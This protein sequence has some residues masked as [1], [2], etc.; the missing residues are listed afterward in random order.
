[1]ILCV[2][3]VLLSGFGAAVK[4]SSE[5]SSDCLIVRTL[6]YQLGSGRGSKVKLQFHLFVAVIVKNDSPGFISTLNE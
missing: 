3:T 4:R 1:M 6:N 5:L 2:A